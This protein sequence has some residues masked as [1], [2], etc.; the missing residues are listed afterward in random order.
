MVNAQNKD[1]RARR[2]L[3]EEARRKAGHLVLAPR[4]GLEPEAGV[5]CSPSSRPSPHLGS[6][7]PGQLRGG[8]RQLAGAALLL[9]HGSHVPHMGF[10]HQSGGHVNT[11][12]EAASPGLPLLRKEYTWVW[13]GGM[14]EGGQKV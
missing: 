13:V 8:R 1:T 4:S 5:Q 3:Q 12:K 11:S 9:S 2:S 14:R 10:G 6:G 7:K